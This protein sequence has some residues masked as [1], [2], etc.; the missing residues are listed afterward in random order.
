MPHPALLD[1]ADEL[2]DPARAA[3]R[4]GPPQIAAGGG[5]VGLRLAEVGEWG[6]GPVEGRWL[7]GRGQGSE[8]VREE[9][10][11]SGGTDGG[12]GGGRERGEEDVCPERSDERTKER[13]R[14][15]SVGW[16][17]GRD[18]EADAGGERE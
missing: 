3:I 12:G 4:P 9:E 10:A 11:T 8:D 13:A 6:R 18:E 16:G 5:D 17:G 14:T 7:G 15:V 1:P 2:L